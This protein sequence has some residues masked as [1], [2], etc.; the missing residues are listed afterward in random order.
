LFDASDSDK[1]GG[2]DREEFRTIMEVCCA[3]IMSRIITYYA[4]LIFF[5]PWLATK[6]VDHLEIEGGTYK[7]MAA[8]QL[9]S[10]SMFFLIIPF[11]WNYIDDRSH[12]VAAQRSITRAVK[13][14]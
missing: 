1:S 4:V 7:E 10:M 8:E 14:D 5:V 12:K 3:Q 2:I 13:K 9:T 6:V 11:V